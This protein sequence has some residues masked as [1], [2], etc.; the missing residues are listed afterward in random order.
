MASTS[1]RIKDFIGMINLHVR[2]KK[3][4]ALE[5]IDDFLFNQNPTLTM[6]D[7][8]ILLMGYD[9]KKGLM[10]AIGMENHLRKTLK[11][12]AH[13]ALQM[14]VRLLDTSSSKSDCLQVLGLAERMMLQQMKLDKHFKHAESTK[15]KA[16]YILCKY[17]R[18]IKPSLPV[19]VYVTSKTYRDKF[20][21]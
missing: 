2:G 11:S 19:D 20:L 15:N 10:Q 12:T 16:V 5:T 9:N 18:K 7:V 21:S 14:V 1:D 6:K 4:R 8:T 17:L 13:F 3:R